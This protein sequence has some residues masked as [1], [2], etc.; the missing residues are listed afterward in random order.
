[1]K[2]EKSSLQ[3]SWKSVRREFLIYSGRRVFLSKVSSGT[4]EYVRYYIGDET[5]KSVWR[6]VSLL[7]MIR[8][9]DNLIYVS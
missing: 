8:T 1:M 4:V 5:R 3:P 6:M 9:I 2:L 7:V